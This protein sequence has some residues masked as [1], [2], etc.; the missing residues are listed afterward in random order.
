VKTI[1]LE[2]LSKKWEAPLYL[3][4]S[5]AA[6]SALSCGASEM[7]LSFRQLDAAPSEVLGRTPNKSHQRLLL[8]SFEKVEEF[9]K[10]NRP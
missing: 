5:G 10:E 3:A 9:L 6:W 8:A 7:A 4:L 1:D 2:A